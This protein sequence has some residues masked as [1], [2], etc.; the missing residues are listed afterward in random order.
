MIKL[1][2]VL[3]TSPGRLSPARLPAVYHLRGFHEPF[4]AATHL[5]GA[6]VFLFLGLKLVRRAGRDLRRRA[7]LTIYAL[8][9][10]VLLLM[11]GVYHSTITGSPVNSVML[12]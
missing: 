2:A 7:P 3:D 12:R 8:S 10:V 5:I 9:C 11:S 4:S 1:F 6:I